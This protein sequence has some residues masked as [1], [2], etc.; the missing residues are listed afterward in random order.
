MK[1]SIKENKTV[2]DWVVAIYCDHGNPGSKRL[3]RAS[4]SEESGKKS[5]AKF[6]KMF[7]QNNWR[8]W[9]ETKDG[10]IINDTRKTNH[11]K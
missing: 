1:T 11:G 4:Y 8:C 6:H 10:K 3:I 2:K 5:W 9:Q 7:S